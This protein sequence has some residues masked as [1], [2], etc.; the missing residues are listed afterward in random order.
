MNDKEM[1]KPIINKVNPK[2]KIMNKHNIHSNSKDASTFCSLRKNYS[3]FSSQK[4]EL[5]ERIFFNKN[6]NNEKLK[7]SIKFKKLS[8]L[9]LE[10]ISELSSRKKANNK[11]LLSKSFGNNFGTKYNTYN[12][13]NQR[14]QKLNNQKLKLDTIENIKK[15]YGE[16]IFIEKYEK[17]YRQNE[18][19]IHYYLKYKNKISNIHSLSILNNNNYKN[20]KLSNV[21]NYE[22]IEFKGKKTIYTN[23]LNIEENDKINNNFD[24]HSFNNESN[25]NRF[26]SNLSTFRLKSIYLSKDLK[27]EIYRKNNCMNFNELKSI[28][29]KN[30]KKM[31]IN[32]INSME[33]SII[34]NTKLMKLN[35]IKYNSFI[36]KIIKIFNKQ[37][38]E[39]IKNDL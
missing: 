35:R 28:N 19:P 34:E 22:T 9:N 5:S 24:F 6:L 11:L 15:K 1:Q 20:K 30:L 12:L 3:D 25:T 7:L 32:Y 37:K 10:N 39:V 23:K 18:R 21:P 38:E 29:S 33:K 16:N 4:S 17:K 26:I 2:Y 27:D 8:N 31:R 13:L 14:L 36:D